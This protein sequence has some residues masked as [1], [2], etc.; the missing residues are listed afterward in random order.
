[1]WFTYSV[2]FPVLS[3]QWQICSVPAWLSRKWYVCYNPFSCTWCTCLVSYL[4]VPWKW[5][6]LSVFQV[7][8]IKSDSKAIL[9]IQTHMVAHNP[10]LSVTHNG[11]NTWKLHVSNVQINDCGT[12]MCQ[13]N[14]DP[15]R[16][17]VH[18][19]HPPCQVL[20]WDLA[21]IQGNNVPL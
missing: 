13:I 15:M 3:V 5:H 6:M 9:A 21:D 8:W 10:R 16:S 2:C 19:M 12:Y 17:Q 14:T 18:A 7:A 20:S 4:T 11:H 1:M